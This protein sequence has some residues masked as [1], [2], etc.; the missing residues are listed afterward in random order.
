MPAIGNKTLKSPANNIRTAQLYKFSFIL[1]AS[2][3][4]KGAIIT[5]KIVNEHK[6]KL[7][8]IKLTPTVLHTISSIDTKS[9]PTVLY[10]I[11]N[12]NIKIWKNGIYNH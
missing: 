1:K 6:I 10:I 11:S 4:K 2:F 8:C 3:T 12:T 9:P 5:I 7:G